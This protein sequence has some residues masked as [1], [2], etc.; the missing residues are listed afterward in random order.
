MLLLVSAALGF[1]NSQ[2]AVLELKSAA[3]SLVLQEDC[4]AV[5][6]TT[7]GKGEAEPFVSAFN[8]V[9]EAQPTNMGACTSLTFAAGT[10][11]VLPGDSA[12]VKI[13]LARSG[14]SITLKCEVFEKY[15]TFQ[16]TSIDDWT[17]VTDE[18]HLMF[19]EYWQGLLD[20][21]TAPVVMGKLQGPR[22]IPSTGATSSGFITISNNTYYKYAWFV[23]TSTKL[24]FTFAGPSSKDV[25]SVW[26]AVGRAEGIEQKRNDNRYLTWIWTDADEMDMD[27]KAKRANVL[28]VE[29]IFLASGSS[30]WH[31]VGNE[32]KINQT[33]F[34]SGVAHFVETLKTR[35]G[36]RTGLHMHPDIVWPC[37][38]SQGIDCLASG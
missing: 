15:I 4:L 35:Y 27:L 18:R 9:A 33:Q 23:D 7:N 37:I 10:H 24:A 8:K 21:S 13:G 5:A 11:T 12:V 17:A 22:G 20:N 30:S 38:G 31:E 3:F 32:L 6:Q 16:V 14:G 34:P 26:Q 36:L 28:G 19:G 1:F 29:M 2:P 25:A